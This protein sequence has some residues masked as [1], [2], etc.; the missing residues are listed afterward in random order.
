V[1]WATVRAMPRNPIT[2]TDLLAVV[3]GPG[4]TQDLR[5]YFQ[6]DR[7]PGVMPT[8][9]GSRF[10]FLAGGGDRPETADRI[11]YDDLVAVTLLE[12]DVPG[13]V[14][15]Q[16]LE[17]PLGPDITR[18][19]E[20]IPT[21]VSISDPRAADLLGTASHASVAWDLLEEPHGM[22]WVI[23]NKLLARKRP[24]LIPVYDRVVA[25]SYGEPVGVWNWLVDLFAQEGGLLDERLRTAG[26]KAGV[27]ETVT[28]LR[29]YDVIVWMRHE[30][31]H[32]RNHCRGRDW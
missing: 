7:P 26:K 3:D 28:P 21:D 23:T 24:K 27:P 12:V 6:P 10:E 31:D 13:D 1:A 25:C 30:K 20:Q 2:L 29:V 14:A 5:D 18:H 32:L 11:T 22:G 17:G 15:L 19:L 8:F 16:L 4:A 9:S